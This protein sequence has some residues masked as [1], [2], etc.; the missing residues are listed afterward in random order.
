M[1][2][3]LVRALALP[4][5]SQDFFVDDETSTHED[6]INRLAA[7]GITHGCATQRFC[8][9]AVV[10]REQMASFLARAFELPA[11]SDDFF[12]DDETSTHESNINSLAAS[13]ITSGCAAARYCPKALVTRGQMA[14]FLERALFSV[15]TTSTS[16]TAAAAASDPTADRE[17]IQ[18]GATK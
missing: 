7:S 2:S 12:I 16:S 6:N 4:P 3:F 5:T 1:A 13:G 8:P 14:A 10:T 17:R 9:K 11:T 15:G 18:V